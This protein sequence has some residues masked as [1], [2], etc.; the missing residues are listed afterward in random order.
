[1][2]WYSE[3]VSESEKLLNAGHY[4]SCSF[5][6]GRA[7]EALLKEL[8]RSFEKMANEHDRNYIAQFLAGLQRRTISSL[9]LGQATVLYDKLGIL[10]KIQDDIRE[11][12]LIDFQAIKHI[13]NL[14]AHETGRNKEFERADAYLMCGALIRLIKIA[15]IF[16]E[17]KVT[18]TARNEKYMVTGERYEKQELDYAIK[19]IAEDDAGI[20]AHKFSEVRELPVCINKES[21]KYFIYIE[22]VSGNKLK[23]V[24][25]YSEIRDLKEGLFEEVSD[26]NEEHLVKNGRITTHQ[27][28]VY[29]DYLK[30]KQE[31]P[32]EQENKRDTEKGHEI[33]EYR[34][35]D[36]KAFMKVNSTDSYL[37]LS[38]ST[39][40]RDEKNSMPEGARKTR[41]NL[42][43]TGQLKIDENRPQL[44]RFVSDVEFKSP[45]A[46][47]TV[48]SASSTNGWKCFNL[49]QHR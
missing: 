26:E 46:A 34:I 45:S 14:T 23:L 9:T 41:Q 7:I 28:E 32:P 48:I 11:S 33:F 24:T 36:A 42:L 4:D 18:T 6:C 13:R 2:N 47:S 15:A 39:A 25:P 49:P 44:F 31:K 5:Q 3:V 19:F 12:R 21:G 22:D 30:K 37:I 27:L 38:G 43:R 40:L 17:K 1:M 29:K 10:T 20:E 16:N 35:K 8:I